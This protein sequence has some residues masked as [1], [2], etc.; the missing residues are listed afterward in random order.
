MMKR[1]SGYRAINHRLRAGGILT[2]Q[3]QA[4]EARKAILR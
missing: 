2:E 4:P 1:H 3:I